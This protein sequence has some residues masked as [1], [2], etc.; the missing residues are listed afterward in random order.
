MIAELPIRAPRH[1]RAIRSA[2]HYFATSVPRICAP[3]Q[4]N[5]PLFSVPC[6]LF[7]IRNSVYPS[8][9]L[10]TAHSLPNTPGGGGG[11]SLKISQIPLTPMESHC[12]INV[13][14]N[15]FRI[16]L[17]RKVGTGRV[18]PCRQTTVSRFGKQWHRHSCL[19]G[20]GLYRPFLRR[21]TPG[22]PTVSHFGK[23]WHRHSCLCG[24]MCR[25]MAGEP[26][27]QSRYRRSE[28]TDS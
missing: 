15:P 2:T 8:C 28:L 12:F 7:L 1:P 22:A 20:P 24:P 26:P 13:P 4:E 27:A 3:T 17:F 14:S 9:F 11:N 16:L 25:P 18:A 10:Q 5:D 21:P 6:A 19:C 23:Q